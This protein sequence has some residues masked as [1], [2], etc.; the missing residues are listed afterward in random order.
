MNFERFEKHITDQINCFATV[1]YGFIGT[2]YLQ[3]LIVENGQIKE[4]GELI[5]RIFRET[6]VTSEQLE[7][8]GNACEKFRTGETQTYPV[9][10]YKSNSK[11]SF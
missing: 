7:D 6:L 2:E 11:L 3:V 8:F 1:K 5:Y 10:N 4:I 9:W